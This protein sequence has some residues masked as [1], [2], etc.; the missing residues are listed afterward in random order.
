MNSMACSRFNNRGDTS[1]MASSAVE[2]RIKIAAG[3]EKPFANLLLQRE[4]V[5][6]LKMIFSIFFS[7]DASFATSGRFTSILA[8]SI[9]KGLFII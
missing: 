9:T 5:R 8:V 6:P 7:G 4:R 3:K 2:A 1:R